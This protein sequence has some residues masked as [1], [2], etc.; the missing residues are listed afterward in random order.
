MILG[1][2]LKTVLGGGNE[3]MPVS[4]PDRKGVAL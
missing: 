3:D 2:T 4:G 1:A